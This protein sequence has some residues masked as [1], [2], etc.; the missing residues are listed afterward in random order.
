LHGA[1]VAIGRAGFADRG[2][3]VH[4]G[5]GV[6]AASGFWQERGGVKGSVPRIV[7]F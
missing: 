4:Q 6:V 2:A 7:A 3:E 5:R 1:Q